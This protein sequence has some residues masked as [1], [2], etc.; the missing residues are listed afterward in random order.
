MRP[1]VVFLWPSLAAVLSR[2]RQSPHE[3]KPTSLSPCAG[4]SPGERPSAL[5]LPCPIPALRPGKATQTLSQPWHTVCPS[6]P[7]CPVMAGGLFSIDKKYFFELGMYD[8]GLDVWGGE[9][10][11][12]SFKV[13]R[14]HTAV[15]RQPAWVRDGAGRGC[16]GTPPL[17]GHPS[18]ASPGLHKASSHPVWARVCSSG[19]CFSGLDVRRRDRDSSVLQGGAHFQE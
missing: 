1:N 11:E 4:V 3:A 9:N 13:G 6:V 15:P 2:L 10:M 18:S 5:S 12:I 14:C 17:P 16:P 8:P 7:R 19:L